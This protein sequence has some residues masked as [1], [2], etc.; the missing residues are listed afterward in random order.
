[1]N[2]ES[3]EILE[4]EGWYKGR[5]IDISNWEKISK[6]RKFEI[7]DSA[8]NFLK[9][10]GG[11]CIHKYDRV[12][13][14]T[15]AHS[16]FDKTFFFSEMISQ[17]VSEKIICVGTYDENELNLYISESGKMYNDHGFLG[18][19]IDEVW[20]HILETISWDE[21]NKIER[22]WQ[23]I[24]LAKEYREATYE[25]W[26]SK[27]I[28]AMIL[29]EQNIGLTLDEISEKHDISLLCIIRILNKK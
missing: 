20:N 19:N 21:M 25:Y 28:E 7:F 12:T 10:F 13:K 22:S 8:K 24:G 23:E 29:K 26:H 5:N 15:Y 17:I 1:M 9:E 18:D 16:R 27:E 2:K 6:D 3:K 4:K 11:I 14:K